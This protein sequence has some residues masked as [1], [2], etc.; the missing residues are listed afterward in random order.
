MV[1]S[2]T[3]ESDHDFHTMGV[4]VDIVDD[5]Q[6]IKAQG[7]T[8]GADDGA[9][10]AAC[11]ALLESQTL[12]HGPLECVFTVEEE[13]TMDGAINLAKAP[14]LQAQAMINVDSE[15]DHSICVGC[16][17]GAE[18][19]VFL[20][21]SRQPAFGPLVDVEVSGLAGGHTGTEIHLDRG[22]AIKFVARIVRDAVEKVPSATLVSLGGGNAPNAIP[23][24]ARCGLMCK[25]ED[26]AALIAAV[27]ATFAQLV[28][29]YCLQ[30][31]RARVGAGGA[32]GYGGVDEEEEAAKAAEMAALTPAAAKAASTMRLATK[33]TAEAQV[34]PLTQEASARVAALVLT[35]PHGVLRYSPVVEGDVDTSNAVAMMGLAATADSK[36]AAAPAHGR[37]GQCDENGPEEDHMWVHCFYRSFSDQQIT[38]A[39]QRIQ[40]IARLAGAYTSKSFGYFNGW[41]PITASPL[42]TSVVDA[43]KMVF[44]GHKAP[45]VYSVHAGLECGPIKNQYPDMH[46]ISIGPTIVNAHSPDEKMSISSME[47][48]MN[49][50]QQSVVNLSKVKSSEF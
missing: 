18:T 23:R 6:W 10:V 11:L 39:A 3:T 49:W 19:K 14:F 47:P 29:E 24:D 27:E 45:R 20:P 31:A 30:E 37:H 46:A 50:L 32:G 26:Q 21:V 22:N 25:P 48:F 4:K 35:L 34:S 12:E 28:D 42:F 43:H 38:L 5:N 44:P 8:L 1:C 13:T 16:A 7:T 9:G 33:V 41:E 2:K 17:G 36:V 40:D 15:E